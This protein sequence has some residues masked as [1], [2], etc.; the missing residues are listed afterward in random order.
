MFDVVITGGQVVDGTGAPARRADV[1]IEGDKI[2]A[3]GD[4][5]SASARRAIDATGKVV[6]P[7]FIDTHVHSDGVLLGEPQHACGLMQGVTT[8]ILG[9]DGL[10]YA[11]LSPNNL[12]A[13][14]WYLKGLN[15]D[16]D[17]PWDWSSVAEFRA[18][19]SGT[20]AINTAYLIPHGAIR[21][22]TVGWRDVPLS[23]DEIKKAQLLI[24][25]SME[26]GAVG[27]STGLSYYPCT[28]S[29]MQEITEFCKALV[30]YD[31]VYVTH[32]RSAY[33]ERGHPKG[34]IHE[35]LEISRMSGA[36]LHYSHFRTGPHN[37]GKVEE[38]M[39]PIDAAVKEG[40]PITLELYPYPAGS[41][42]VIY[43]LPGWANEG[44]P[45]EM[46]A[47]LADPATRKRLVEEMT[48]QNQGTWDDYCL[49]YLPSEKNQHLEGM[50]FADAARLRGASIAET[51]CQL[52]LEENLVVGFRTSPPV[53]VRVWDQVN[54]DGME[55][56]ARPYYMVGSD[57][58]HVGSMPHPRAY[59]CFARFLGRFR[60]KYGGLSLEAMINRMAAVPADTFR[61]KGRGYLKPGYFADVVVFDP[62]TLIDTA[63]FED[64]RSLAQGVSQVLV[65][66]TLAVD[67]GKVTGEMAGR[68]I[69]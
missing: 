6:S 1:G 57:A 8:E 52:L 62:N 3:I 5:S 37:A 49:T 26:E 18:R 17:V 27:F 34:G 59:G 46:L 11:P 16:S 42:Y 63:T 15:G 29:T 22:E 39:A 69:P 65:N 67:E 21:L 25:Q 58:I 44:G 68:A 43:C 4:L 55:L 38:L 47:R 45:N 7:G 64:P 24:A 32:L 13:Y 40:Q 36:R 48:E 14:R 60:R 2:S 54:R 31:G 33:P 12:V 53:S 35:A 51:L 56:L 19:F 23:P 9:Q 20:V 30:P 50:S 66:G 61:L 10:S 41:G 28:W